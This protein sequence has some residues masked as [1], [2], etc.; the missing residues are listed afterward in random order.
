MVWVLVVVAPVVVVVAA[1][2]AVAD[3]PAHDL[4]AD[5]YSY[6]CMG[7]GVVGDDVDVR[8]VRHCKTK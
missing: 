7:R 4:Q 5:H 6:S 3:D 1:A 8:L 2:A